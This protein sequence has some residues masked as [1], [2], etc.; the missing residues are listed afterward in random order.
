MKLNYFCF[1]FVLARSQFFEAT[2]QTDQYS[3]NRV[4]LDDVD[5]Q[6]LRELLLFIYTDHAPNLDKL[7]KQLLQAA[8]KFKLAKLKALCEKSLFKKLGIDNVAETLILSEQ[9]N[10]LQLKARSIEY[11]IMNMD[12][13]KGTDGWNNLART[14]PQLVKDHF[15]IVDLVRAD[16]ANYSKY[17]CEKCG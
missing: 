8:D 17:S 3:R 16:K 9:F 5:P 10:A 1:F 4:I 13:V 12:M 11:I 14:N 6:V 2:F 15:V 7:A